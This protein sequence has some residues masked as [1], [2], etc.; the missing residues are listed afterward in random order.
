[1]S[2]CVLVLF[3]SLLPPPSIS[4]SLRGWSLQQP[5]PL[6]ILY[7]PHISSRASIH[8]SQHTWETSA[9]SG[10]NLSL[11]V[12]LSHLTEGQDDGPRALCRLLNTHRHPRETGRGC[13]S[14]R[15]PGVVE[16]SVFAVVGFGSKLVLPLVAA[17]HQRLFE[18]AFSAFPR[19]TPG[20]VYL[21]HCHRAAVPVSIPGFGL[22]EACAAGRSPFLLPV[23]GQ[24]EIDRV[25]LAQTSAGLDL[26]PARDLG[27][28]LYS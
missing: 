17:S 15:P 25:L 2:L 4:Y 23:S 12:P 11:F 3:S 28:E 10:K 27:S 14:G 7:V 5:F 13:L 8:Y 1:M 20:T 6:N 9:L 18:K 21:S 24:V 16:H 26:P 19:A 22:R